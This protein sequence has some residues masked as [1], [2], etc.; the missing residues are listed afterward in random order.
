MRTERQIPG[1]TARPL[2]QTAERTSVPLGCG[3]Q[4]QGDDIWLLLPLT[5]EEQR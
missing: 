3:T 1:Q 2:L 4:T 5:A